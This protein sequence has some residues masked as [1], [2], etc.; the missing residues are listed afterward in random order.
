MA[1]AAGMIQFHKDGG[2]AIHAA[3]MALGIALCIYAAYLGALRFKARLG[4]GHA[5]PYTWRR[6]LMT[7]RLMVLALTVGAFLGMR[8][9]MALNYT[10]PHTTLGTLSLWGAFLMLVSGMMLASGKGKTWP[11]KSIHMLLGIATLVCLISAPV[12]LLL[13]R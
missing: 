3:L 12:Y 1:P 6:H 11:L 8:E 9:V 10:S 5:A 13:T 2:M 7:G 4:G